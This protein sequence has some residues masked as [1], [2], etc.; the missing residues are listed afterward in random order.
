MNETAEEG[1]TREVLEETGL[2]ESTVKFKLLL[3]RKKLILKMEKMVFSY[4]DC[5]IFFE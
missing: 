4:D 5:K 2:K 3:G 1:V